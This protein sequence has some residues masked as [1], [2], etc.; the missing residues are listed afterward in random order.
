[1]MLTEAQ[2]EFVQYLPGDGSWRE[3]HHE[4][5]RIGLKY[6]TNSLRGFGASEFVEGY[7]R[8]TV[9]HR[10]THSGVLARALSDARDGQGEG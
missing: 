9:K 1:M 5:C 7:Y 3:T 10:L 6:G 8:E 2:R 4:I